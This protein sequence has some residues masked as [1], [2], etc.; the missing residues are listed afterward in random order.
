MD[1]FWLLQKD[2]LIV[3]ET[4][5]ELP[6]HLRYVPASSTRVWFQYAM[7]HGLRQQMQFGAMGEVRR[8]TASVASAQPLPLWRDPL[9]S[10]P[11]HTRCIL[12]GEVTFGARSWLRSQEDL[13][14]IKRI[15]IESNPYYLGVTMIVSL[16]HTV[17]DFLAFKNDIGFW[18]QNKSMEG[19]S[20]RT[21]VL[22]ACMQVVIFLYLL[23]NDTSTLIL[24]SNGVG[25][26]IEV[27]P[28][29][30]TPPRL[31]LTSPLRP[32]RVTGTH[33]SL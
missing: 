7:D 12:F 23:D 4:T 30:P 14:D 28:A 27:N 11:P 26:A 29:L 22:N 33:A 2:M 10:T 9:W 13:D 32:C 6:L 25:L 17:F 19:L 3:N 31:P 24:V 8:E 20:A 5:T 16:V 21:M 18:R 15:F 1:D